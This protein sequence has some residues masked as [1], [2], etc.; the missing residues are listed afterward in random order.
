M[1][2][3]LI[4]ATVGRTEQLIPLFESLVAQTFQDFTLIV[5]DQNP[6]DRVSKLLE[7]FQNQFRVIHLHAEKR[8]HAHANNVGLPHA[9]GDVIHFPDDDCWYPNDL[10]ERVNQF[11]SAHPE[12]GGMTG[13]E[14]TGKW[15]TRRE[16]LTS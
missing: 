11:L 8:G 13:R 4:L 2:F 6:D 5:V 12:W 10:F 15:D 3:S 9:D 1:R 7:R 16:P 14:A